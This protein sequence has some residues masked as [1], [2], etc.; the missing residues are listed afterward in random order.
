LI[1]VDV[2]VIAYLL[3]EGEHTIRSEEVFARD[4]EWAA[5]L[6][7]RSEWYSILGGYLRRRALDRASAMERLE[8]AEELVRG[9]EHRV[10]G[11]RVLDL[12]AASNCSAYDCEY[13]A[14]ADVLGLPLVTTDQQI[15]GEF[16]MIARS[17]A[18]YLRESG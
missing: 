3:I 6:L 7:W 10:D 4:P 18:E 1:V 11:M 17:P 13:V 15:L 8:A 5:P 9:R 16:P 14:L 12:V 2:N